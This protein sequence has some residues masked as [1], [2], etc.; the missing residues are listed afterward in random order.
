MTL[1]SRPVKTRLSSLQRSLAVTTRFSLA[2]LERGIVRLVSRNG[3]VYESSPAL[4]QS[5]GACLSV[6]NAMMDGEIVYLGPDSK[7]Q[8]YRAVPV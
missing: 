2:Y 4:C 7:P 5:P 8:I 3:N 6:R 1:P